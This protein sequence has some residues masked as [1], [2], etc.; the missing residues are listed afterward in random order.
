MKLKNNLQKVLREIK[1][2]EHQREYDIVYNL[3]S[4]LCDL[5]ASGRTFVKIQEVLG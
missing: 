2:S 1:Y 4:E 3:F 5:L